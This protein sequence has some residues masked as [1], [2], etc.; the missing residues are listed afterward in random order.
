MRAD[1]YVSELLSEKQ[2]AH[3]IDR[4]GAGLELICFSVAQ[5]LDRFDETVENARA[6]LEHTGNPPCILHGPF[7]DLNPMSYDSRIRKVTMER[8]SQC[9][10][11]ARILG[12]QRI[13]YHSGMI[14]SVYFLEGWAMRMAEFWEEFLDTR[15]GV[16][17]CMENV[18]DQEIS[19][20]AQVAQLVR[21]PDFGLCLDLGHAHCYGQAPAT[22]WAEKLAPYIRHVH[23]HDNDEKSDQHFGLGR[24]T[25][26]WK[27]CVKTLLK[28]RDEKHGKLTWTVECAEYE[29]ALQSLETL[30][31]Y[32]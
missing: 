18:L 21:H 26:P 7:L 19:A 20:F 13:V 24:G 16:T 25:L 15:S 23:V 30:S 3:I 6:L 29:D 14:P 22:E 9:Y 17:V 4:T 31:E 5:N 32:I 11:A 2:L 28:G 1:Y 8:F 27:E 12:A 10:E